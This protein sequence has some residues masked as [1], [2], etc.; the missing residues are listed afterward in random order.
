MKSV[1]IGA[2]N[3]EDLMWLKMNTDSD[4]LR[5]HG[6]AMQAAIVA[7]ELPEKFGVSSDLLILPIWL[8]TSLQQTVEIILPLLQNILTSKSIFCILHI[9]CEAL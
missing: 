2:W 4:K 7:R 6:M 5:L 9:K 1:L 3:T 8:S